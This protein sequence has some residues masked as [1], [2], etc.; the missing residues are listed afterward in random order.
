MLFSTVTRAARYR[1]AAGLFFTPRAHV[2]YM[3]ARRR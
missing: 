3:F 1:H 2:N